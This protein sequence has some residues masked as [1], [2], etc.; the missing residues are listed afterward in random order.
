[1]RTVFTLLLS[2]I[3]SLSV[4]SQIHP[5]HPSGFY[6]TPFELTL[7]SDIEVHHIYYT[8]DG[9]APNNASIRYVAPINIESG[10]VNAGLS[11]I[12]TSEDWIRPSGSIIKG[13]VIRAVAYKNN[14][15]IGEELVLNYLIEPNHSQRFPIDRIFLTVDSIDFFS[16]E[17]GIYVPGNNEVYNFY[18][19]T[20]AWER[21]VHLQLFTKEGTMEWEQQLGA[22]IHGRSSRTNPQ[23]SLRLY[24]KEKYGS[25]FI[26]HSLFGEDG[27]SAQKRIILRA[28]DRLFSKAMFT[29]DLIHTVIKGLP[30]DQMDARQVAVFLNGEYW[31][32]QSFRERLDEQYLRIN[33]SINPDNVDIVDWDRGPIA[34]E[35]DLIA[36]EQLMSLLNS[37]DLSSEEGY[38][39]LEKQVDIAAFIPYIGTHLFFAN[40]DFPNNNVRMWRERSFGKKWGFFFYDCDGCMR[41]VEMNSFDRFTEDRNDGNP[42]SIMLSGLMKNERFRAD[43]A[44]FFTSALNREFSPSHLF[45]H[46]HE[47][48]KQ[49]A[50][51]VSEHIRRWSSP[52]GISEW[53]SAVADLKSF[54]MNRATIMGAQMEELFSKPYNV[55][56]NPAHQFLSL[57]F[58]FPPQEE[59]TRITLQD[60]TGRSYYPDNIRFENHHV[61][62]DTE[63][64][65]SGV[66]FLRVALSTLVYS[67]KI[68]IQH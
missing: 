44:A 34:S 20:D 15:Q 16:N 47:L 40:E 41:N 8:L 53:N 46:I 65:P 10:Y 3:I 67:D 66:Y 12:P 52:D 30:I 22:R 2:T 11:Y 59:F 21:P 14:Q 60:I 29:D 37:T 43:L 57:D 36:F 9:S 39:L 42:V 56:P 24:A 26:F 55:Y 49:F 1:M 19:G 32:L 45:G 13:I 63:D 48:E 54:A 33:K 68:I 28:P 31:G 7:G 23:K 25:P 18:Q 61:V 27:P 58:T 5:S 51:L 17:K 64:I 4:F 62:I 35:G 6:P 50:P 38:A